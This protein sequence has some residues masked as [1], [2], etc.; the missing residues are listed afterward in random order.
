V[1]PPP[2]ATEPTTQARTT[3]ELTPPATG[4]AEPSPSP[5]YKKW[6]FW[7]GVGVV[8]VVGLAAASTRDK[9]PSTTYGLHDPMFTP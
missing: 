8:L 3:V 2:L 6:W 9:V 5:F 7:T 1:A 4:Q